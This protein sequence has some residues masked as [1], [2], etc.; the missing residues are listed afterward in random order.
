MPDFKEFVDSLSKIDESLKREITEVQARLHD[1]SLK[2]REQFLETYQR[3]GSAL[4]DLS[5]FF[6]EY[7]NF[8]SG[9]ARLKA[10]CADRAT[11]EMF[12]NIMNEMKLKYFSYVALKDVVLSLER[13]LRTL[14]Y[15]DPE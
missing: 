10:G 13:V 5:I 2:E 15:K 9:M 12:D 8:N 6:Y 1:G 7:P 4:S 3:V 11:R 14:I